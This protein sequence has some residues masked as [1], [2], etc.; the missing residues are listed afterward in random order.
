MNMYVLFFIA[1]IP[2]VWLMIS[3]GVLKTPGHK[4]TPVTLIVTLVLA[5]AVW[6]MPI[7]DALK[8]GLEG[9]ASA[10]WPIIIVIIAAVFIYNLSIYTKSM[11]LIKNM[12]TSITTDQRILVLILAWGFGGFLEAI[13]GFGTA[14]AIPASIMA[15]LGFDPVFAA[16]ICLIANTT[17]TAF[18]AIGL[19]VSTLAKLTNLDPN[20]LSYAV[21]LQLSLLIVI[22]PVILVMITGKSVKAIKGVL[23]ISI[24]SGLAF[25]IP[26]VLTA[27]YMGAE[28]PAILGS[29][30][31]LAVTIGYAKVFHKDKAFKDAEKISFSKGFMA[32]VPFILVFVAIIFTSSLFPGISKGLSRISTTVNIYHSYTFT[33][34]NNP[35]SLIIIAGVLGGLM[36]GAKFGEILNVL[37]KTIKQMTKSAITIIAI[38]ALAK[39]MSYSGMIKSIAVVLVAVTGNA[40]PVIAPIIG[41]LGTFVTGSDTSA[42]ILFGQLQVEAAKSLGLNPYW[43]AAANTGGAT[44]GKMISPQS[45]AVATAATGLAGAEGKIL[46]AT[47]KFCIVY[48]IVLGVIA[49]FGG[50]AFNL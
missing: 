45:I 40:Y 5:I 23:G 49:Y 22:V 16:I 38:V 13:A 35:G 3:L 2:I 14:V 1:L 11:D 25:A 30:V 50:A 31:C 48:V 34:I 33:W 27:K 19:P 10:V 32:W 37:G 47:L 39:V 20:I 7:G 36:Q 26:E 6:K 44:A 46:N 8:A 21:G 41:A 28:L 42:N 9:A 12:M 15:A 29:I 43:L 24:V 17:P 18:G 4:A